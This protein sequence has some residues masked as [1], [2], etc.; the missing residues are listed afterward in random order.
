MWAIHHDPEHWDQPEDFR[1]ERFL[2]DKGQ[3]FIPSC[4]MPFGAGPR[5][6]VGESLARLELF[7]FVSGLLQ[8]FSFSPAPGDSLPD[9]EGRLGVVLQPLRYT[10][11][12]TPRPGWEGFLNER[13]HSLVTEDMLGSVVPKRTLPQSG[14]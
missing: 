12:V 3:R 13:S 5:V 10:L 1:P 8:R 14:N 9:L 7:L 6:C 11:T 2:D 4:F